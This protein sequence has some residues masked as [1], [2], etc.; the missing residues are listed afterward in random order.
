MVGIGVSDDRPTGWPIGQR[1]T[2][3]RATPAHQTLSL[4]LSDHRSSLTGKE[5]EPAVSR[6]VNCLIYPRS[7]LILLSALF[8]PFMMSIGPL[9]RLS[10][11][12]KRLYSSSCC[13]ISTSPLTRPLHL[14][15][16]FPQHRPQR[17]SVYRLG[18][19][20]PRMA[21]TLPRL[22]VFEAISGHDPDS[23]V[24][25]HSASQRTFRYGELL[26]DVCRMRNRLLEA[27]GKDDI[28]GER[29]AF[30]VENSYDYVGKLEEEE[31]RN[32][33]V[34]HCSSSCSNMR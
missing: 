13:S 2:A 5:P 23:T 29:I 1:N 24:V 14:G 28:H 25:V 30:L 9:L 27:A 8:L 19:A 3:K 16:G 21:S 32:L 17:A 4:P 12:T 11:I 31:P 33:A 15:H 7:Y 10:A 26:G 34:Y 18:F 22:P 6:A 20:F